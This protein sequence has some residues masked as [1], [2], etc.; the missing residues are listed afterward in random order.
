[1]VS[2]QNPE[3]NPSVVDESPSSS[4]V[5]KSDFVS[6]TGTDVSSD[7]ISHAAALARIEVTAE[8]NMSLVPRIQDF[9]RFV[10]AIKVSVFI[11]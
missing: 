2:A 11:E 1:M 10:D 8:E 7:V 6:K 4:G 9:L 3:I 5:V